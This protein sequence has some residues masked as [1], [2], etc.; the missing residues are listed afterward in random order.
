MRLSDVIVNT[1]V[2]VGVFGAICIA[3]FFY[4]QIAEFIKKKR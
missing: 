4:V 2:A 3:I 1:M